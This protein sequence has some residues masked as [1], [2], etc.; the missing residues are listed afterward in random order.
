MMARRLQDMTDA[1]KE[2]NKLQSEINR[3][4]KEISDLHRQLQE[5]HAIDTTSGRMSIDLWP[6]EGVG[7]TGGGTRTFKGAE[8]LKE[9]LDPS[10]HLRQNEI[11]EELSLIHI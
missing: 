5:S 6:S 2:V 3:L 4:S 9:H 11:S 10:H 8:E 1:G 7:A